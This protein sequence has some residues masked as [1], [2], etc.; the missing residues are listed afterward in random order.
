MQVLLGISY[1]HSEGMLHSDIKPSNV[2]VGTNGHIKLAD[3]GLSTTFMK[4]GEQ[5]WLPSCRRRYQ[6]PLS[7]AAIRRGV[8]T[9]ICAHTPWPIPL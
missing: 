6:S 8:Q 2:L 9:G 1:L 4:Q 7:V 3:F 5:H